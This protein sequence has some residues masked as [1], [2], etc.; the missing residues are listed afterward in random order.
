[1]PVVTQTSPEEES[2]EEPAEPQSSYLAL[3][4]L[5]TAAVGTFLVQ[6]RRD[7]GLPE[8]WGAGDVLLIGLAANKSSRL[9]SRDR[10]LKWV[11]EPFTQTQADGDDVVE[12]PRGRGLRRA[13]GELVT[14]P[15][16]IAQW[17]ATGYTAGITVAPRETRFVMVTL[18][19]LTISDFLQRAYR[20]LEDA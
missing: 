9:V 8:S 3:T 12:R 2:A 16:C 13:V 15:F 1:M 7:G 20:T 5:Y 4:G 6:R 10:I 17:L 11:R 19:G 14:C 18:A